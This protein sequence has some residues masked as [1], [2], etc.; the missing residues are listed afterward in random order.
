MYSHKLTFFQ[1]FFVE[2]YSWGILYNWAIYA[3]FAKTICL[4]IAT[5]S[6]TKTRKMAKKLKLFV[7]IV[8][9]KDKEGRK[10]N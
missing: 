2:I 6:L 3:R 5:H 9:L 4:L 8:K 1:I 7:K 10:K